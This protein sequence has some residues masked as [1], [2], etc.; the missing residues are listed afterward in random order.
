MNNWTLTEF[1][2][3]LQQARPLEPGPLLL[4]T[5]ERDK[6]TYTYTYT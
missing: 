2:T 3:L 4:P 6:Q 5:H 1:L